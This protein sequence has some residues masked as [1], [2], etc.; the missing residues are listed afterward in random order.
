MP[1]EKK[2]NSA[3]GL[4]LSFFLHI[5]KFQIYRYLLPH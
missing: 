5:Q 1:E 4:H 2:I 3:R